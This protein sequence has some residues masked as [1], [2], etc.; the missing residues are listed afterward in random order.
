M[1]SPY[2]IPATVIYREIQARGYQGGTRQLRYF[3]A[4]LKPKVVEEPLIRFETAP[5][6][7]MQVDWAHFRYKFIKLYAFIATLGYSRMSYVEFTEDMQLES[8]IS[9]HEHAFNYFEGV[10]AE[11]LYDNM[12]TVVLQRNAY[13]SGQHRLHP[14]LGDFAKHYGFMPRLCKPYRAQTKG[15]V[16]RFIR[17]LRESFFIPLIAT[18][19]SANLDLDCETA[20]TEVIKWLNEVANQ[21][22]HK[23]INDQPANRMETEQSAMLALPPYYNNEIP[24]LKETNPVQIPVL[25]V[26]QHD[27]NIY[28]AI[29]GCDAA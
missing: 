13:G 16:E 2:W 9:C 27:L 14:R 19:R 28:D 17:Y 7:Q 18:L 25:E 23:T 8:F 10:P 20:N 11:I 21:R 4:G 3:M 12:K 15:K 24:E 26:P 1:A 22:L 5:G 29:G 6:K